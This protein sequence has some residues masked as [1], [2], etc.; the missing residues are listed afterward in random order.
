MQKIT[1]FYLTNCPY[2]I[3]ANKAIDELKAENPAYGE[4]E[5]DR[6][7]E[8]KEPEIADRYDYYHVPTMYFGEEK[9]YEANPS[10]DY[11]AIKEEVRRVFDLAL[12]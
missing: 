7:E 8:S 3:N 1:Y 4:I 5:I 6:I 11:A 9:Q 12:A 10:Q 2:C